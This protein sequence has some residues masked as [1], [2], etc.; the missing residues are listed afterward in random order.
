MTEI[1]R[2]LTNLAPGKKYVVRVRAYSGFGIPSDWSEAYVFTA[3]KDNIAPDTLTD[4]QATA[5]LDTISLR[6]SPSLEND[7]NHYEVYGSITDGFTPDQSSL[8]YFGKN[9]GFLFQAVPNVIWFFRVRAVDHS[10]NASDFTAQISSS[11]LSVEDM[12]GIV[13]SIPDNFVATARV[14]SFSQ[15]QV[16]AVDLTW[17][18]A[19]TG[20]LAGFIIGWRKTADAVSLT[21][22]MQVP[23]LQNSCTFYGFESNTDYTFSIYAKS[24]LGNISNANQ[25]T[26]TTPTAMAQVFE[27]IMSMSGNLALATSPPYRPPYAASIRE[28]IALLGTAGSTNTTIDIKKNGNAFTTLT[29]GN[30]VNFYSA[31]PNSSFTTT[32]NLTVQVTGV[33]SGAKDLT[34]QTRFQ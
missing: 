11:A 1:N 10:G 15:G 28:V 26:A 2:A 21:T 4:F 19:G 6:W 34:V 3:E 18:F 13:P 27:S 25:T 23:A 32:D 33:G 5:A 29:L 22:F 9:S 24:P 17:T 7:F 31:T 20:S 12:E 14:D 30:G 8:I 16:I